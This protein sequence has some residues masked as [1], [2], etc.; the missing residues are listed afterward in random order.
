M[1]ELNLP[2]SFSRIISQIPI[3]K[4][5]FG[6]VNLLQKMLA[7]FMFSCNLVPSLNKNRDG[8]EKLELLKRLSKI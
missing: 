8:P 6:M 3:Q 7:L 4:V 2:L 5:H 1:S